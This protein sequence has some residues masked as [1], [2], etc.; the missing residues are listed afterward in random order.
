MHFEILDELRVEGRLHANGEHGQGS[1]AGGGAGGTI[2]VEVDHLDGEGSI[3][4][5]GGDGNYTHAIHTRMDIHAHTPA[6]ICTHIH[7]H[8][9]TNTHTHTHK[10]THM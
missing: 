10:H 4:V 9:C 2:M 7:T 1:T 3:E 5:I 8:T 6:H